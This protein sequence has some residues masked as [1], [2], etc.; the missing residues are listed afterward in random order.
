MTS[1]LHIMASALMMSRWSSPHFASR[2]FK[3]DGWDFFK[4]FI[5]FVANG[6]HVP[7]AIVSTTM[8]AS[9]VNVERTNRLFANAINMT[10]FHGT[11][12]DN[13]GSP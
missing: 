3:Q 2:N 9:E 10:T 11:L 8:C 7:L 5:I 12:G 13:V 6:L 1:K 4:R